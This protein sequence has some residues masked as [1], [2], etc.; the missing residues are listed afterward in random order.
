M[1][2]PAC[3][4]ILPYPWGKLVKAQLFGEHH[5][6]GFYEN[7]VFLVLPRICSQKSKD[8]QSIFTSETPCLAMNERA[9]K[10]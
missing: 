9:R 2:C 8:S 5:F 3:W 7:V 6:K 4:I 10:R 1:L